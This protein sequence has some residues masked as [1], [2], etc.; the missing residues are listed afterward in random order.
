MLSPI[1]VA[2]EHVASEHWLT[3]KKSRPSSTSRLVNASITC[4]SPE[5][6]TIHVKSLLLA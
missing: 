1:A 4:D 2:D 6:M 5:A 3:V